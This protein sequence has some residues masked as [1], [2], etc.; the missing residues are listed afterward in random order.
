M[1][2][3]TMKRFILILVATFATFTTFAQKRGANNTNLKQSEITLQYT[4]PMHKEVVSTHQGICAKCNS[5]L[6]VDR[7]GSKQVTASYKCSMHPQ[8]ASNEKGKC[9]VCGQPLEK[10]DATA[11]STKVKS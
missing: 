2:I 9:P 6:V 4:C 1:K 11:D 8:V 5:K 3:F 10:Q 7:R